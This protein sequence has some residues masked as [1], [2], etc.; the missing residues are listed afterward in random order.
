[1]LPACFYIAATRFCSGEIKAEV[2]VGNGFVALVVH[3]G[4]PC[5]RPCTLD[6]YCYHLRLLGVLTVNENRFNSFFFHSFDL[7]PL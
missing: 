7:S 2:I 4:R 3:T 6:T 1:M 5:C